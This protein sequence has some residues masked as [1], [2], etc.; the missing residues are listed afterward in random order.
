MKLKVFA[1]LILAERINTKNML[2]RRHYHVDDD[3]NCVLCNWIVEETVEHMFFTCPFSKD[4][5]SVVG[6]NFDGT[7]NRISL[8]HLPREAGRVQCLWKR[9]WRLHGVFGKSVTGRS[10]RESPQHWIMERIGLGSTYPFFLIVL[11]PLWFLLLNAFLVL[12]SSLY[13]I[14]L[15]LILCCSLAH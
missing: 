9:W 4:Y 6:M 7:S 5:W 10:S 2:R 11:N 15:A 8:V 14:F 13:F 3:A 1:W 12:G